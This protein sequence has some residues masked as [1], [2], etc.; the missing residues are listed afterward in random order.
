MTRTRAALGV[1]IA[2]AA[3]GLA[4]AAGA[5]PKPPLAHQGRWFLDAKGR[6]VIRSE[7]G[8]SSSTAVPS[9]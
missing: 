3:L 5:A 2:L 9:P 4:A 8:R 1:F 6:V 7:L